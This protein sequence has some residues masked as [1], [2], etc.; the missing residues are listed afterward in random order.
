MTVDQD[1]PIESRLS[2]RKSYWI[3][4]DLSKSTWHLALTG[5]ISGYRRLLSSLAMAAICSTLS[6]WAPR[7]LS[8]ASCRFRS[9]LILY[10]PQLFQSLLISASS[11]PFA[12]SSCRAHLRRN[13]SA[14]CSSRSNLKFYCPSLMG[15]RCQ[16]RFEPWNRNHMILIQY[17]Q[18][19]NSIS[20]F[21]FGKLKKATSW[22]HSTTNPRIPSPN[23]PICPRRRWYLW[24][25]GRLSA[26][27]QV[28]SRV[29][30]E[31][32]V[33][34][35]GSPICLCPRSSVVFHVWK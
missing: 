11:F 34:W 7:S 30:G 2:E 17:C 16:D 26:W 19:G 10:S 32:A 27:K 15:R 8:K 31:S 5:P 6:W 23:P 9:A 22:S 21:F 29:E 18:N 25:G 1:D 13:F 33:Y 28:D 20:C 14:K 12:H 3:R 4:D 24:W 35:T